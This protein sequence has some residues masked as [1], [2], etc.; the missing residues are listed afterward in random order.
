MSIRKTFITAMAIVIAAAFSLPLQAATLNPASQ[1]ARER[2]VQ[3]IKMKKKGYSAAS[4][5]QSCGTFK[6]HK[7]GKCL[8]ARSK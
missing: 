2:L 1:P 7:G 6:Y 8:D 4:S 5:G 3:L